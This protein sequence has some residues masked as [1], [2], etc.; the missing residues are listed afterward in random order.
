MSGERPT[1]A[2]VVRAHG[3]RFRRQAATSVAQRRALADIAACRTQALGGHLY[4][5]Q[6]CG[7]RQLAYNPCGNRHCPQCQAAARAEWLDKRTGELLPV[8]YFHV[9]F[10][11]P[12]Q[13]GPLALE[14]PAIVYGILFRAAA[15]TLLELSESRLAARCGLLAVL[16]TWGQTL[17][18]H[19]HLHC[20][21]PGGGI[22][23]D[24]S[25]WVRPKGKRF[26]LPARVLRHVFRAKVL[27]RLRQAFLQGEL[28]FQG[29]LTHWAQERNFRRLLASTK[30]TP[31]AVHVEPPF[32]GPEVVLKYLARYTHRVAIS[33]RRLLAITDQQVRFSYKDYAHGGRQ[34]EMT[35]DAVEFLRRF[36]QHVLPKGFVRIRYYGLLANC[37]RREQLALTRR[38]LA[39]PV[40]EPA[41]KTASAPSAPQPRRCPLCRQ[42]NLL[43][44]ETF[45]ALRPA[46]VLFF[47]SS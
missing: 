33:D 27:D 4:L 17:E 35:L 1:L 40:A 2:A 9:V 43:L 26:L 11:L 47:D 16:H 21:V 10:T 20:V 3:E 28:S 6:K 12:H 24:G 46:V 41:N 22:G 45:E 18:H 19:P 8:A 29:R 39:A 25:G 34:R 32:G 14:N 15:Q 5:C 42:G 13:L 31:W 37:R 7:H 30:R 36:L 44:V 38:L 23:L